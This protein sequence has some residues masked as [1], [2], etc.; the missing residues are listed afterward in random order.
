MTDTTE[1]LSP[2]SNFKLKFYDSIEP[3]MGMSMSKFSLTDLRTNEK[4]SFKSLLTLGY[5]GHSISWSNSSRYFSL[6]IG[7]PSD[8][9]LIY[10]TNS[11][12]FAA[13]HF[14]NIWVL[15]GNCFD[16]RI[17]IEYSEEQVPERNIHNKYPTKNY[18]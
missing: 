14:E 9:F 6:S 7:L 11:M 16:D 12:K 1:I 4:I 18:S 13:I 8:S 17:E 10:D 15:Q 3:R 5:K 2:D